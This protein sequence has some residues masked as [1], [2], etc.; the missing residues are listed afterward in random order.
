MSSET[1]GFVPPEYVENPEQPSGFN[2]ERNPEGNFEVSSKSDVYVSE[3][4]PVEIDVS[5]IKEPNEI[6]QGGIYK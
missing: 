6:R 3:E 4:K 2:V 5:I 1:E